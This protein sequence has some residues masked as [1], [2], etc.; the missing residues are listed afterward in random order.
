[1]I[2]KHKKIET[3]AVAT[4]ST[5]CNMSFFKI[6]SLK[7]REALANDYTATLKRLQERSLRERLG[8]TVYRQ[9]LE[10]QYEPIIKSTTKISEELK[11]IKQEVNA[12][13][14]HVKTEKEGDFVKEF[15]H[16]A[17]MQDPD[18]DLSYGIRFL[19]NGEMAM[20]HQLVQL[21]GNDI[22]VDHKLY[23][24]TKGLWNL[25]TNS[26]KQDIGE[27][28]VDY[29]EE[30]IHSYIQ[31]L[32]NTDVLRQNF[33]RKSNH[34]RNGNTWKWKNVLKQIWL[35]IKPNRQD[36]DQNN[37]DV[38]N[39]GSGIYFLPSS[40][41]ALF[42]KLELLVGE[43]LAGNTTTRNEL[44]A[45]LDQLRSRGSVSEKEYRDINS[46]LS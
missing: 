5:Q 20:G 39:S 42:K 37:D 41:N 4:T 7:D 2:N 31:L 40:I 28:G 12:L 25:I 36:E 45:V 10:R 14:K 22:I 21:D 18:L 24:G 8:D 1:M 17:L 33:D 19:D 23:R 32:H 27:I 35:Q 6:R 16:R 34:P 13:S 44:V 11:P 43:F 38:E 46:L 15:K 9:N 26:T 3:L 30:D 29:T